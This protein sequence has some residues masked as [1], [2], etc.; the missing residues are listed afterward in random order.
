MQLNIVLSAKPFISVSA[1]QSLLQTEYAKTFKS[2]CDKYEV[3]QPF[4]LDDD[5]LREF[6]NDVSSTWKERKRELYQDG[7]IESGQL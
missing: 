4:E 3:A 2:L 6:F 1:A 7:Q 5:K